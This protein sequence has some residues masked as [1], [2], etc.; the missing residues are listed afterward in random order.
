MWYLLL[1]AI[2]G[3][4]EG[5]PCKGAYL[6]QCQGTDSVN[7]LYLLLL[8]QDYFIGYKACC[9]R[10]SRLILITFW[11]HWQDKQL[12]FPFIYLAVLHLSCSVWD[13]Q[14]QHTEVF[15]FFKLEHMASS[16]GMR[17]S[18]LTRDQ[19]WDPALGAQSFN[20]WTTGKVPIIPF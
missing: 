2:V 17:S 6:A 13:H 16:C 14:L 1:R 8:F 9:Y 11:Q 18:S 15:Y 4:T 10:L 3:F 7:H 5:N 19:T 12:S 20:C